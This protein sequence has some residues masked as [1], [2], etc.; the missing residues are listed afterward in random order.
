MIKQGSMITIDYTAKI[1]D[2]NIDQ[3]FD[4][5][6]EAVAKKNDIFN[7]NKVYEPMIIVLGEGWIP[8]GL[9]NVI[10]KATVGDKFD[11]IIPSED[12]YGPKDPSKIKLVARREFQKLNINPSVGDRIAIGAQVG[13]VLA[14][15]SSRVRMDYNHIL[16]G[17]NI[18]YSVVIHEKIEKEE[19]KIKAL[20]R[21]RLPGSDLSDMKIEIKDTALK[22]YMPEQIRYLEYI[23]FA[24]KEIAKDIKDISP[25][26]NEIIY[27]EQFIF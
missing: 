13:S 18:E 26:Y 8:I 9:E 25:K 24:K 19:E 22:L 6:E 10:K 5:T 3:V 4:T 16:A 1:S 12:A 11:V 15:T 2:N 23:Q 14:V 17:K 7:S 21:R 27:I 20:I